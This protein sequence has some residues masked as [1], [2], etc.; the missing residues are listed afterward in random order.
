MNQNRTQDKGCYPY[1]V[2]YYWSFHGGASI[3]VHFTD[4]IKRVGGGL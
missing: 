3:V 1:T 2:I 4:V